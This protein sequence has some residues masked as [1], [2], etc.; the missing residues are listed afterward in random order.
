VSNR[1]LASI[2][3]T[4]YNYAG[5][6][7]EAIDSALEQT[8]RETEVIVVDDGSTDDSREVIASYGNRIIPLLNE[9]G[10]HTSALN[11]GF[12]ASRGQIIHFVDADD[13]LLPTAV[14]RVVEAFREPNVAKVHWP[15]LEIDAQS[16]KTGTVWGQNLPE[17][18]LKAVVLCDGPDQLQHPPTTGNAFARSFLERVFPMPEME[19][20]V[21]LRDTSVDMILSAL[22]PLFGRVRRLSAP[23]ACYRLHGNNGYASLNFD[24]RLSRD[25]VTYNHL[26]AVVAQHCRQMGLCIDTERWR[27]NSWVLRLRRATEDIVA[28]VPAGQAFILVDEDSWKSDTFLAGRERI[29]FLER[30]GC[31]W[32]SPPDDFTAIHEIE[33][34]RK[35]GVNFMVFA[36]SAFWWLEY[37]SG[38]R[39][40]L[41]QEFRCLQESDHLVVF[42]LRKSDDH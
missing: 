40:Y 11:A 19:K 16:R 37:Y 31:Y 38:M 36:W 20:S 34:L 13:V 35:S 9:N 29:R 24:D 18:D 25:V 28:L 17:G 26:C 42:D 14:E 3:I 1:I 10:G 5:Y 4:N 15:L 6:L 39:Q 30:D 23:Y 12:R 2:I 8:Y 32:G 27:N 21:N 22:A 41:R 7:Q 33:R